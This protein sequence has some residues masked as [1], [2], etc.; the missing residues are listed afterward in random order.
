MAA[1]RFRVTTISGLI[2][3]FRNQ[4]DAEAFAALKS[5]AGLAC[6]IDKPHGAE[7]Q[8]VSYFLNGSEVDHA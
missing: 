3:G 7:E 1:F 5:R 8:P 4:E 2:A 6:V